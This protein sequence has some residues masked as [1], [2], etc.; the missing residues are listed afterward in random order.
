MALTAQLEFP[1]ALV[2]AIADRVIAALEVDARASG[3]LDM[4]GAAAY[5]STTPKALR[6]SV[7][8]GLVP[9]YQPLG[10]GSR[11]LF[12]RSELDRWVTSS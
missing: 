9:F 3:W 1:E 10:K 11:Y 2:Q 6:K 8:R 12:N 4:D 5:L 7:Q